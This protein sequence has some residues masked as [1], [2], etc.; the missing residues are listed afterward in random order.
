MKYKSV[1]LIAILFCCLCQVIAQVV[2]PLDYGLKDA[3]LGVDRYKVLLKCHQD[4]VKKNVAVSYAGVGSIEIEIPE[5]FTSIPLTS[6]TDFAGCMI[7]VLNRQK[8]VYLY[9]MIQKPMT[10]EVPAKCIDNAD[11]RSVDELKTGIYL[12][13]VNDTNPWVD[14]RKG[15][16]YGHTRKDILLLKNGFANNKP[17]MPYNNHQSKPKCTYCKVDLKQKVIKNLNF[18]RD[19]DSKAI[20]NLIRVEAQDNVLLEN[21]SVVTPEGRGLVAD[22]MIHIEN[23][24]NVTFYKLRINGT[25]SDISHSGYAFFL[26]NIWNHRACNVTAIGNWGVYG[27]NNINTALIENCDLNRFDIHCY[28]RDITS[29][30]SIYRNLYNQ[31]SA[32]YGTIRYER[33]SFLNFTPYLNGGSYNAFTPVD[34]R[35]DNCIFNLSQKGN[36]NTCMV[37]ISGLGSEANKRHE[38]A[39]KNLPNFSFNNCTI[40]IDKNLKRWYFFNLGSV[41]DIKPLGNITSISMNNIVINGDAAFDISN[42]AF[43]TEKP[44]NVNFNNVYKANGGKR[45]KLQMQPVTVGKNVTVRCNRKLV[46]KK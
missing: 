34:V 7:K 43:E 29:R 6:I 23:C 8:N 33:C 19:I 37:N 17:V 13:I 22:R 24:T 11:C 27:T 46:K 4:A 44:L 28:G 39:K 15:Y 12:L 1:I 35:F 25:Y 45:E 5:K 36:K 2:N 38:L 9:S 31:F 32:T 16:S 42:V 14:N 20:T 21:I 30:N 26:N 40:N 18:T 41:K 3:K 10:I